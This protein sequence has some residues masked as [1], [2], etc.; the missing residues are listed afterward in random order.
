MRE[1]YNAI[2]RAGKYA[3]RRCS[4]CAIMIVVALAA[5]SRK[6]IG[7][8][9]MSNIT[10]VQPPDGYPGDT[11][12][13]KGT[14][15]TD[16]S[17]IWL[18]QKEFPFF[19]RTDG[20]FRIIMPGGTG[21]FNIRVVNGSDKSNNMIFTYDGPFIKWLSDT[22]GWTGDTVT[23][24]AKGITDST[25]LLYNNVQTTLLD[26]TDTT[27]SFIVPAGSDTASVVI[28]NGS[29][30]SNEMKFTYNTYTNPVFKPILADPT[31]FRDPVTGD[32]Y[33]YGTENYWSTDGKTH[34][35]AIVKSS[36]MAHWQYVAD[37]FTPATKPA[38]RTGA[39]IWAPDIAYINGK[40][41]LY[42]AYSYWDDPNP[43]IGLAIADK[44]EG[45]FTDQGKLFFS[46]EV[47]VRNSIDPF[48][49]EDGGKKY[50][51]WGS[52][53]N[54]LGTATATGI[55][56]IELTDDGKA[57]KD[58]STKIQIA[59]DDFEAPMIYKHGGYYWFF[60]SKGSCCAGTGSTYRVLV[61]RA[62][63]V[64]GPYTGRLGAPITIGNKGTFALHGNNLFVGPG[65]ESR[66]MTDKLGQDWILYHAMDANNAVID[67]VNQRALM[68]DKVTW[69]PATG[70]PT[71]GVGDG[72]VDDGGTPTSTPQ[73]SPRF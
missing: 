3:I 46:S 69:D 59:A 44:P 1:L 67:G 53:N 56:M 33:A 27:L 7:S 19:D 20:Q 52:F 13:I 35:V 60:G 6:D 68:L 40:Y 63:S 73:V 43:G 49:I 34:I 48:Y 55:Y 72:N 23:L 17:V 38:W 30:L 70:W 47:G 24:A 65:H 25:Y 29:T 18:N 31:V 32:F 10:S 41:F 36:D 26:K 45:P 42:Y 51:V 9:S 57:I 2:R 71:I 50:L 11:V 64:T 37:A 14:G 66:I 16:Q 15:F 54:N 39:N 12:A 8:H 22:L 58:P 28:G 5:C 4:I 21:V 61:G 62:T